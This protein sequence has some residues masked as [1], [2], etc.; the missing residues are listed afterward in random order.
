LGDGDV[1]E[2]GEAFG[3]RQALAD[4]DGVQAFEVGEDDEGGG[5]KLKAENLRRW[6]L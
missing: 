6:L 5:Q 1:V 2:G 4:E 3:L